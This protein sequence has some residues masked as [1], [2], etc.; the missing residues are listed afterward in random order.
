[1]NRGGK[2]EKIT[3][4]VILRHFHY[5]SN[6]IHYAFIMIKETS[7]SFYEITVFQAF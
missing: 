4:I 7:D 5:K 2:K 1:M 6:F 3:Q